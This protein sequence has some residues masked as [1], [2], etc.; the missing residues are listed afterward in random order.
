MRR[1]PNFHLGITKRN[2]IYRPVY[3]TYVY[4]T[5]CP[6][7]RLETKRFR[8]VNESD[9]DRNPIVSHLSG[10]ITSSTVTS[11]VWAHVSCDSQRDWR[12]DDIT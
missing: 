9:P 8:S 1:I 11:V 4:A 5:A 3:N 6:G 7:F 12:G 2:I 10:E